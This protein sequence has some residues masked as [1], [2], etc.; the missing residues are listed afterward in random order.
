M[1]A[2][3]EYDP[4]PLIEVVTALDYSVDHGRR[5]VTAIR[6]AVLRNHRDELSET[7]AIKLLGNFVDRKLIR[8]SLEPATANPAPGG[9]AARRKARY[10][11][12]SKHDR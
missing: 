12:V 1:G 10:I 2:P 6:A 5:A 4:E 9:T 8:S 7:D 11:R 3:K